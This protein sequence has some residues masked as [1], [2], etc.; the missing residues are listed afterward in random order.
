IPQHGFGHGRGY[1][2]TRARFHSDWMM[3]LSNPV[4]S[5][6]QTRILVTP[7]R[8]MDTT[9]TPDARRFTTIILRERYILTGRTRCFPRTEIG[10]RPSEAQSLRTMA[11]DH[12]GVSSGAR[13][14]T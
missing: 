14:L 7:F 1:S 3:T 12:R 11:I 9:L 4:E 2:P 8:R 10:G 6:P 5:V 13:K